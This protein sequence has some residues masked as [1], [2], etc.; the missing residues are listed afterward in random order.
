[1]QPARGRASQP[2]EDQ[3]GREREVILS[4]RLWH[5]RF[6]GDPAIIGQTVRLDDQNFLV[7]GVMPETF[8]G[9]SNRRWPARRL[10]HD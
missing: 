1:V 6:G 2:G 5:R 8:V 4:D 9:S 10:T 7:S 3:P